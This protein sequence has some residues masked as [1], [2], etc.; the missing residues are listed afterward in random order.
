MAAGDDKV[1]AHR[2]R[3]A[4]DTGTVIFLSSLIFRKCSDGT[5]VS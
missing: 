2:R 5:I 1:E 3:E 4:D